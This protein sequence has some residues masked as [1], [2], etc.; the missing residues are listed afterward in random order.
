MYNLCVDMWIEGWVDVQGADWLVSWLETLTDEQGNDSIGRR[1]NEQKGVC[2][3]M[4]NPGQTLRTRSEL[5]MNSPAEQGC[6]AA[7]WLGSC[8]PEILHSHR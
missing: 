6:H 2:V 5:A 7:E 3:W 1:M 8:S 4:G